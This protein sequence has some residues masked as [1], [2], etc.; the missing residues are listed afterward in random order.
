MLVSTRLFHAYR[1]MQR[2]PWRNCLYGSLLFFGLQG[3]L[4]AAT[5]LG[6]G[7]S[8]GGVGFDPDLYCSQPSN[9]PILIHGNS[10]IACKEP[11]CGAGQV[12]NKGVCETPTAGV[13]CSGSATNGRLVC[14]DGFWRDAQRSDP[15]TDTQ[16]VQNPS[17]IR[18][19]KGSGVVATNCVSVGFKKS[20][21]KGLDS[22]TLT[23]NC[24][25]IIYVMHCHTPTDLPG[26][27]SSACGNKG[28]YFQQAYWLRPGEVKKNM[29]TLPPGTEIH[30]GVCSGGKNPD[31]PS[32]GQKDEPPGRFHCK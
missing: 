4:V 6:D 27:S 13:K 30:F 16:Q 9:N 31:L 26:T 2:P 32:G 7:N 25:F 12:K 22:Q 5:Q 3:S 20:P 1:W 8:M 28:K 18:N 21:Y 29:F 19:T 11:K 23:N 10:S 24:S 14:T 17:E 15:I